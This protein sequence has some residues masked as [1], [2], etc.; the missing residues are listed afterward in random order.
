[1]RRL[2]PEME[3]HLSGLLE[4]HTILPAQFF[5]RLQRTAAW[6][7]EQK[8]MAA[9]LE[10]AVDVCCRPDQPRTSKARRLLRESLHW[11]RC[12]DRTWTF[13]FLRICEQLDLDP[14]AIRR[15]VRI[16]RGEETAA[17]HRIAE[18]RAPAAAMGPEASPSRR[19]AGA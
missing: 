11:L 14:G 8:L 13:S 15:G 12:N 7:G 5:T 17:P 6:S 2:I 16:R 9:I 19:A 18:P 1:M 10:D 3:E 4:P